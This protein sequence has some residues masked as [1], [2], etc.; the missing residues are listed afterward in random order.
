MMPKEETFF[1]T[2]A[3]IHDEIVGLLSGRVAEE[4]FFDDITAGA[5]NDI[6]KAMNLAR[7]YVG[8]FGMGK[9][10]LMKVDNQASQETQKKLDEEVNSLLKQCHEEATHIIKENQS[11]L[12]TIAR[13]LLEKE[14]LLAQD[15]EKLYINVKE[16]G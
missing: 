8:S 13:N 12:D 7:R 2:K 11:L 3:S 4:L 1:P 16:A 6:E 9:M 15:I 14:T 5:S 10:G